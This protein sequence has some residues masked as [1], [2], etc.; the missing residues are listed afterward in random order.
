[1]RRYFNEHNM[2]QVPITE[3]QLG[4]IQMIEKVSDYVGMKYPEI[5]DSRFV[6]QSVDHYLF[7]WEEAESVE[8]PITI[9]EEEGFSE[10]MTP[11]NIP[12]QQPSAMEPRPALRSIENL[13]NSQQLFD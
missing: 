11:Q 8:N 3:N 6:A 2:L 9:D 7:S 1:M 10:T 5:L 4:T 12:P 13:Q